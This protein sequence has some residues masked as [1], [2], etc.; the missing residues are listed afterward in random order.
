MSG[1]KGLIFLV[2]LTFAFLGL[3]K[4]KA[5]REIDL[6]KSF[7][8]HQILPVQWLEKRR[9]EVS[10]NKYS[11][12]GTLLREV[13]EVYNAGANWS[14]VWSY[15]K[16]LVKAGSAP[17][18]PDN[19]R[20]LKVES[21]SSRSWAIWS[22]TLIE[23]EAGDRFVLM[24]RIEREGQA[25]ARLAAALL[26]EDQ[27]KVLKWS[28]GIAAAQPVEGWQA[29][30]SEFEIPAGARWMRAGLSGS[31]EGRARFDDIELA[32]EAKKK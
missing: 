4:F 17:E 2:L 10:R 19:S 25:Q 14:R 23:V 24:G 1:R 31:G 32:C 6:F 22:N 13:F 8:L 29:V 30:R 21:R 12:G 3:Y 15:E 20:C 27:K 9:A 7:H 5:Q 26:A 11:D 28:H 18:G 16:G